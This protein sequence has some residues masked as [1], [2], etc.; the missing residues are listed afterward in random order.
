MFGDWGWQDRRTSLQFQRLQHWLNQVERPLCIEI[1]A[2]THIPTVRHFSESNAWRLIRINPDEAYL[3]DHQTGISL[4]LGGRDGI[5][6]L[7]LVI[8]PH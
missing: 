2:G 7:S 6:Q 8:N 1:G 3:P 4:P 5:E